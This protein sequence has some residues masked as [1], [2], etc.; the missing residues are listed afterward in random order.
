[1][2]NLNLYLGLI[3]GTIDVTIMRKNIKNVHLKVYRNLRVNLSVPESVPDNWIID[4]LQKKSSW[5]NDKIS[6]YKLSNGSNTME[7][8]KNGTT[9][10]LLGKDM[11]IYIKNAEYNSVDVDEKKIV[12]YCKDIENDRIVTNS[13]WKW[14]HKEAARVYQIELN[15]LYERVI[16]KY[17]KEKPSLY[18]RKMKTLWGSCTPKKNK[19]TLN[20]YLLKANIRCIQY[21]VLH[22]LAHLL[23][24]N[25]SKQFYDFL[26]IQMPDWKIRKDQLDSE[27]VQGLSIN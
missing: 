26:T 14:W 21:V 24:P 4:F 6:K 1:M 20:E 27:V 3:N 10:Q 18:V 19:I 8:I 17:N 13:F 16:K 22:E 11:R 25:H 5:I 7:Y 15:T 2:D 9:V 23:Y 12:L